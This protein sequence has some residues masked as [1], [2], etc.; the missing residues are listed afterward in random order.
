MW[1]RGSCTTL[2][3]CLAKYVATTC[4]TSGSISQ[5][6][7]RSMSG[8]TTNVPEVT[9]QHEERPQ[10]GQRD[11]QTLSLL[12]AQPANENQAGREGAQDR[13]DGVGGIDSANQFSRVL[14][15]G[16]DSSQGQREAGAPKT[17]RRQDGP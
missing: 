7:M 3:F 12:C 17:G 13:P 9:H 14:A 1:T 15:V 16:G 10:R 6:T 11:K 5:M 2:W 4:G 8:W